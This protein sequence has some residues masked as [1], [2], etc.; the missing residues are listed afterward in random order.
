VAVLILVLAPMRSELRPVVRAL[1]ARRDR[2]ADTLLYRARR[3]GRDVVAAPLGVGP[4]AARRATA[5]LL[6][7][8]GPGV[9]HVVVSGIAGGLDPAATV[10]TVLVPEVVI[11]L[12]NDRELRPAPL[13]GRRPAG[14]VATAAEL[15]L[16]PVRLEGLL[17]RGV[18]ALD[19]ETAGVGVVCDERG[20]PWTAFR[21]VSDRPDDG[22]VDGTVF[23][24]LNEDGTTDVRAGVRFALSHPARLPG[25]VRLARDSARGCG[26]AARAAVEALPGA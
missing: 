10:G 21:A 12:A 11:D 8:L 3:R 2:S 15:I 9:E 16:D 4:A 20:V 18:T 25:L 13:G 24:F 7:R 17:A 26:L 22:L 19:M 23:S 5:S 1:S 6:D 14:T